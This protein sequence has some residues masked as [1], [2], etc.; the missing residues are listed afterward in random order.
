[1]RDG[2]TMSLDA[3]RPGVRSPHDPTRLTGEADEH[4]RGGPA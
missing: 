1:M 3:N 2:Q 4:R